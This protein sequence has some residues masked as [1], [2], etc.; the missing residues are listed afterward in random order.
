MDQTLLREG[1][2]VRSSSPAPSLT[3]GTGIVV[4]GMT[5][6]SIIRA[7]VS[8]SVAD[9]G[10]TDIQNQGI[11]T[12]LI[13]LRLVSMLLYNMASRIDGIIVRLALHLGL[14]RSTARYASFNPYR[15]TMQNVI[16]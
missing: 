6:A 11:S 15:A 13:F 14:Y 16:W 5:E 3:S 12:S 1:E 9:F 4:T 7:M 2:K 10:R 8:I